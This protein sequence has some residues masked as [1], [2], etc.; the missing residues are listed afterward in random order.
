MRS[1]AEKK[2]NG[3]KKYTDYNVEF[4]INNGDIYCFRVRSCH[5]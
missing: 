4:F 1:D 3:G 2:L 5:N